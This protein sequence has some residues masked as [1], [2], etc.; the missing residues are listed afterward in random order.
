MRGLDGRVAVVTGGGRGIGAAVCRRLAA[1]GAAVAVLDLDGESAAGVARSLPRAAAY[2]V[3]VRD[4]DGVADVVR[5]V[6]A[7]H[8]RI[9]VL[10]PCAGVMRGAPVAELTDQAWDEVLGGHLTGAFALVRAVAP[11]MVAQGYGRIV[12]ISSVAARGIVGHV[13]YGAAK[14]GVAGMARSLAVELG[15]HGVNVNAVAPGFIATRMTREGAERRG[16]TW[17]E[18]AARAAE[19][20]A[21]RR[22]GTPEDVAAVVAFLAGADAGYVTG[23]VIQV[24]GDP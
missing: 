23:Q 18:H 5:R 19:G 20:V 7:G 22:I 10:V 6:L 21:L 12:L 14:A 24:S 2:P 17:A 3:D 9:D 1:E 8:G 16:R 4:R 15:P 13:N 11:T